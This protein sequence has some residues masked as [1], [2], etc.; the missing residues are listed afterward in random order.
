MLQERLQALDLV[1]P[2]QGTLERGL[3]LV[4][5]HSAS[6]TIRSRWRTKP[7]PNLR[8]GVPGGCLPALPQLAQGHLR[9]RAEQAGSPDL[10]QKGL[11]FK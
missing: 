4:P 9:S 1:L 6:G 11:P 5:V 7:A 3:A 2:P 10:T 8:G